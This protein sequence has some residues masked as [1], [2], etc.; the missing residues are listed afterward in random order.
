MKEEYTFL[1]M[2]EL[3]K[4]IELPHTQM[5]IVSGDLLLQNKKGNQEWGKYGPE[6]TM[7]PIQKSL[8]SLTVSS[9]LM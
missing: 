6:E 5:T 1:H 3:K 9:K 4:K 8:P 7:C 2:Q